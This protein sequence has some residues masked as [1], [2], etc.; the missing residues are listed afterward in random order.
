MRINLSNSVHQGG[1]IDR[2]RMRLGNRLPT[3]HR[4]L[5]RRGIVGF[6]VTGDL[7]AEG[8]LRSLTWLPVERYKAFELIANP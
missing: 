1:V 2:W 3:S 6:G 4:L 5:V 7:H 8:V